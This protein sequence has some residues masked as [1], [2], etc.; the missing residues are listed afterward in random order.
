MQ[1]VNMAF[2]HAMQLLFA[3]ASCGLLEPVPTQ[4]ETRNP[5]F[6]ATIYLQQQ[7]ELH[8]TKQVWQLQRLSDT[9]WA[10]RYMAVDAVCSRF[11]SI[12]ATLEII[13]DG[14]DA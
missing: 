12:L 3:Q 2:S 11:D 13:K 1:L 8:P 7:S 9:R 6:R 5:D 10:C 4:S 14:D